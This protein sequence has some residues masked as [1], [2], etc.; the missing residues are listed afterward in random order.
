MYIYLK[1]PKED[2][3]NLKRLAELLVTGQKM[4]KRTVGTSF[5]RFRNIMIQYLMKESKNDS[6]TCKEAV[7]GNQYT[8]TKGCLLPVGLIRGH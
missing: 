7:L 1:N 2:S 3:K 6:G 4:I 8:H 5:E